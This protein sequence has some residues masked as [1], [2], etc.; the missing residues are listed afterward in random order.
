MTS[1]KSQTSEIAMREGFGQGLL[2][3]GKLNPN[4]VA[5]TADLGESVRMNHFA[6]KYPKRFIQIGIAEQNM[7]GVAAGL[8]LS[9]KIPYAGSFACFQPM[10]NLDQIRTSICMMD[11]P[12][13]LVS[14]HAGFSFAADGIQIQA[15]EDI[16]IMRS[17]PNMEV[18][19]PADSEQA[20]AITIKIANTNKP[21]YLRIGR[22][23]APILSKSELV[24]KELDSGLELGVAQVLQSGGDATIIACGYMVE[25]ALKACAELR[26]QGIY[27][28]VIN[29][30]TIKP[31]DRE[32]IV[33]AASQTGRI[34]SIEEAQVH[35]GL[36][37]AILEVLAEAGQ[38]AKVKNIGVNDLFGITA[39][40]TEE[41]WQHYGLTV[42][43]I[44]NNV[45]ALL[46]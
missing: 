27:A 12:V 10:R 19:V 2:E 42:E 23:P 5:L 36:G 44:I 28:G 3:L 8:G 26:T 40:T 21:A 11:S 20:A 18:Y 31:I 14:S 37:S 13:K 43:N 22:K 16:A 46:D 6:E 32:A 1:T 38:S 25:L 35:G 41:L 15:L 17:L 39:E 7:A 45:R 9:G 4:V 30:H 29:M 24:D 34:V 33:N